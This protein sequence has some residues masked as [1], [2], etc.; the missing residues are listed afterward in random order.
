[1]FSNLSQHLYCSPGGA[2]DKWAKAARQCVAY[3]N[4]RSD[5]SY[6]AFIESMGLT[7]V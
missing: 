7:N 1:M 3:E 5:S 4:S 2:R 6:I